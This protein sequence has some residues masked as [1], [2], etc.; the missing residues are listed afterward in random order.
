[1]YGTLTL[2]CAREQAAQ[3]GD[4]LRASLGASSSKIVSLQEELRLLRLYAEI[5]QER[6]SGRV[7][8]DWQ[9]APDVYAVQVP[10]ILL[11]PIL[12]SAFNY[13]IEQTT[14][15]ESICVAVTHDWNSLSIQIHN[16]GSVLHEEWCEGIGIAN[17][18][19][20]LRVLH[21]VAASFNIANDVTA[22][23]VAH[24]RVPLS[25]TQA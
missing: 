23:I 18:R 2:L 21:D 4:P 9:I 16:T 20:R 5:M 13:G 12:E 22:G 17:C 8:V 6:F 25:G 7:T 3:L 14:G 24:F 1:M 10:A 19:E 11:Q 15:V